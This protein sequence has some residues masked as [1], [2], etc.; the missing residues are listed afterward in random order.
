MH[1][2]PFITFCYN[3]W[4]DL[5]LS[6]MFSPNLWRTSCACAAKVL[7]SLKIKKLKHVADYQNTRSIVQYLE[8]HKKKKKKSL[9]TYKIYRR[10]GEVATAESKSLFSLVSHMEA[11]SIE[12]GAMLN[13]RSV[14]PEFKDVAR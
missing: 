10:V 5:Q 6:G 14:K 12:S 9:I 3:S 7:L 13:L 4:K 1:H 8:L 11:I 2:V